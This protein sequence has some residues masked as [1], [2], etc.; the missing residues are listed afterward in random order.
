MKLNT[1]DLRTNSDAY[2]G[3]SVWAC[4]YNQPDLDKKPLRNL[5]PTKCIV[6]ASDAASKTVYY[7]N[8]YLAPLNKSNAPLKKEI[9]LVDNTGY[10]SLCGNEIHVFDNEQECIQQW[11]ADVQHVIDIVDKR[12]AVVEQL[13][14]D[15][16][17]ALTSI[18][19]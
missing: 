4:H 17:A 19:L 13:W 2:I 5:P 11:N 12:A 1:T 14:R 7:S 3:Q 15:K 10:R 18:L 6:V 16:S 9:M 8:C